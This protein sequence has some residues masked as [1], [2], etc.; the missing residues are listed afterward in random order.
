MH[1][2]LIQ[3]YSAWQAGFD[4]QCI[5]VEAFNP[6]M[7]LDVTGDWTSGKTRVL[8]VGQETGGWGWAPRLTKSQGWSYLEEWHSRLGDAGA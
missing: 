4:R 1:A 2:K 5:A 6:P 3:A 7:L 8:V